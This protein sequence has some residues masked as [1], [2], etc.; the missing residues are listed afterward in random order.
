M[1]IFVWRE[2]NQYTYERLGAAGRWGGIR[3]VVGWTVVRLLTVC[4]LCQAS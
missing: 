2:G 4:R 1:Y 3:L